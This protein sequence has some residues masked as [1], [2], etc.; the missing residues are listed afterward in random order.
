MASAAFIAARKALLA[1]LLAAHVS[2]RDNVINPAIA[3]LNTARPGDPGL[4]PLADVLTAA[5]L[6]INQYRPELD[7][8][9]A[10]TA[11]MVPDDPPPAP[12]TISNFRIVSG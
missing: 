11:A 2:W 1:E 4:Q 10:A 7:R 5:V 8:Q 12:P 3:K 9:I 6:A